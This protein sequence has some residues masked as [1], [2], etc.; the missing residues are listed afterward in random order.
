MADLNTTVSVI[1]LNMKGI[2]ILIKGKDCQTRFKKQD[3]YSV[4]ERN[5]KIKVKNRMISHTL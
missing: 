4:Y 2:N 1:T 5:Y 3:M